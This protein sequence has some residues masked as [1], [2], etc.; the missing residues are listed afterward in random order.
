MRGTCLS[1]VVAGLIVMVARPHVFGQGP[2]M[3]GPVPR[4]EAVE[5]TS[6][7]DR[8]AGGKPAGGDA[9]LK[10]SGHF[11][12]ASDG[13]VHVP[14]TVT[15]DEAPVGFESIAMYVRVVPRDAKG[16][17][18]TSRVGGSHMATPVSVP[19]R[20]FARGNPTAG[21]ASARLSLLATE[22]GTITPPFQGFF[23]ARTSPRPARLVVRRSLVVAPGEYDLYLA[24]R[25][26]PG[27]DARA[28]PK[29]ATLQQTLTVPD[30][31]ASEPAMSSIILADRIDALG[32]RLSKSH[33]AER[34]YAFGS[35]EVFPNTT[36]AFATTDL[37]A[38]VFFA[39]N[40]AVDEGHLPDVTVEY[41][42]RQMSRF[43]EFFGEL[44]PQRLGRGHAAPVF[45]HKAGRQLA[46]TQ[47]LPL[48]TFP[49]DT[50]ELEIA[51]RD[52][53]SGRSIRRIA[54]FTVSG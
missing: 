1:A 16:A 40:L 47:A 43:G 37:L 6:L 22:L 27:T 36:A 51:V 15:L 11:L 29:W 50:Y 12:R 52:N 28:V 14:F 17:A 53:L 13:R 49:P 31:V 10:W 5:L 18:G 41:R 39:Y 33:E 19:E 4:A 54:R 32:E 21:E 2:G 25:E 38:I 35:A 8:V 42:F 20:Q 45:D 7:I 44:A 30:L 3:T 9:W 24:V 48:A 23:V 34:P 46:V 26:R